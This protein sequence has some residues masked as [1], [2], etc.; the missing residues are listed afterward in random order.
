MNTIDALGDAATLKKLIERTITEFTDDALTNIRRYAFASCQQ[1]ESVSLPNL[2][3]G[4][5]GIF[6]Y[7]NNLTSVSIPKCTSVSANMFYSCQILESISLP[8]VTSINDYAFGVCPMLNAVVLGNTAGVV[9]LSNTNAFY[10]SPNAIIY[11][12]DALVD[13]YKA[14]TNWSTYADR[15]KGISE[16]PA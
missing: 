7:C 9:T 15:I 12:P 3:T 13:S 4:N 1:L 16:L 10:N 14:A 11:V 6:L 2:V 5:N 8:S